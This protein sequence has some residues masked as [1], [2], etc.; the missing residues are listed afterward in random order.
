[1][2]CRFAF[3]SMGLLRMIMILYIL[4]C[5]IYSMQIYMFVLGPRAATNVAGRRVFLVFGHSFV[6]QP[7]QTDGLFISD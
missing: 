3:C 2:P 1:M 5:V 7:S 6:I 4:M